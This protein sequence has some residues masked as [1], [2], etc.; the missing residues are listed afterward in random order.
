MRTRG[1]AVA[2][3]L[4]LLA[5]R[6]AAAPAAPDLG[7][8]DEAE[9]LP[10]AAVTVESYA[11]P[12]ASDA[13]LEKALHAMYALEYS[14]AEA[15][16]ERFIGAN[17]ENPYGELFLTGMLWWRA[18]TELL[19]AV[20]AP[21]LARRFDAHSRAAVSKSK[22]LFKAPKPRVR[23]EAYF[24]AGMS[25]GLR[26]QWRL[27]NRQYFKAYL[28]GKKAI[29]YLRKS[30]EIDPKLED[31]YLGLG[32][33][34]YQAAVLPGVL[35]LGALLLVR[36]DRAGGLARIRR[37]MVEGQFSNRQAASFLL[38]IL[39][40]Q[41]KDVP[42]ALAI[43]RD[44]RGKFP[45]GIYFLGVEASLL[46][47]SGDRAAGVAAWAAAYDALRQK[48]AF[49][50]KGWAV[51]CGAYGDGCLSAANLAGVEAWIDGALNTPP[52][53]PPPG[54]NGAL[55]LARGL[56]R[57]AR[58]DARS[59]QDDYGAA[60]SDAQ[61]PAELRDFAQTCRMRGCAAAAVLAARDNR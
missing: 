21:D 11:T 12:A 1:L 52:A 35:R 40:T 58:A 23:A 39:Q 16:A 3:G 56:A 50:T 37:A 32:I 22:R 25:L 54:W 24:V 18:A 60:L 9:D 4:A 46:T 13:D 38:T 45:E 36:G 41:E 26:G 48:A 14:T 2:F 49:R 5:A 31:A 42:G 10:P 17:P 34:D 7:D 47:A 33:F 30:V 51:L 8:V 61:L 19:R 27:T 43:L 57:D 59:A 20:D 6:A 55:H 29:K 53:A 28:D 15:A 44:L